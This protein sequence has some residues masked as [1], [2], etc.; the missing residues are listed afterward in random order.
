MDAERTI[1]RMYFNNKP[2]IVFDVG[3][4]TFDFGREICKL[5]PLATAYGFEAD[6]E[7]FDRSKSAYVNKESLHYYNNAV[8]DVDGVCVLP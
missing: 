1:I 8:S 6:V 7:T 3:A 2:I 5:H 4:N